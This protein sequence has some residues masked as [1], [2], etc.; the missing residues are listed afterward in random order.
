M[1]PFLHPAS[2]LPK[3][4]CIRFARV[5]RTFWR[6]LQVD[7]C[8]FIPFVSPI[9]LS[10]SK[11]KASWKCSGPQVDKYVFIPYPS[12][13]FV[14][15]ELHRDPIQVAYT[16]RKATRAPQSGLYWTREWMYGRAVVVQKSPKTELVAH[17][18]GSD[19]SDQPPPTVGRG[20]RE[21]WRVGASL[22]IPS[23]A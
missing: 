1:P 8:I 7:N 15:P 2:P 10:F 5:L 4:F 21:I 17:Q 9:F 20:E 14:I 16:T 3:W 18:R 6:W 19:P 12:R 23:V 13:I 11:T 22:S